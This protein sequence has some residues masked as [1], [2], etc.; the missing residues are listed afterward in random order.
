MGEKSKF[1]KIPLYIPKFL[2]EVP[3]VQIS[4]LKDHPS[5]RITLR[6]FFEIRAQLFKNI[7]N[8]PDFSPIFEK[9]RAIKRQHGVFLNFFYPN[10][11]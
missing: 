2:Q 3:T 7:G 11:V 4:G 5:S 6:T 8:F 10:L 9:Y 1:S